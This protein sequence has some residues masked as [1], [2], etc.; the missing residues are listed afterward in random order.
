M[1]PADLRGASF[2]ESP[3][4]DDRTFFALPNV[5]LLSL[6]V[7]SHD[8]PRT[9]LSFRMPTLVESRALAS[10]GLDPTTHRVWSIA[11]EH[12]DLVG[13]TYKEGD[14]VEVF[15]YGGGSSTWNGPATV[16]SVSDD[17]GI[18]VVRSDGRS[19]SGGFSLDFIR[20]LV[21]A[22][23]PDLS[24]K[25]VRMGLSI[26]KAY[27]VGSVWNH[28]S[29][30]TTPV[31]VVGHEGVGMVKVTHPA[32]TTSTGREVAAYA[33]D[34]VR[35]AFD[36]FGTLVS[37]TTEPVKDFEN[38]PDKARETVEERRAGIEVGDT[39]RVT[40][41]WGDFRSEIVG[42][43]GVVNQIDEIDPNLPFRVEFD[44]PHPVI[45]DSYWVHA[46]EKVEEAPFSVGQHVTLKQSVGGI[47][48]PT[49]SVIDRIEDTTV[50]L[51][52]NGTNFEGYRYEGVIQTDFGNVQLVDRPYSDMGYLTTKT[53]DEERPA[54]LGA[55]MAEAGA[56]LS[57]PT[58]VDRLR[59]E[60]ETLK[61]AASDE[62]RRLVAETQEARR[63]HE[64][65]I[66]TIGEALIEEAT[67]RDWCSE[68]DTVVN[69]MNGSLNI[70][71]PL[72][73]TE[74]TV[75]LRVMYDVEITVTR[76]CD[77]SEDDVYEKAEENFHY[78]N[79]SSLDPDIDRIDINED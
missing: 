36:S 29:T 66:R 8:D 40:K 13:S 43:E 62:R 44:P 47:K 45:G 30:G 59:T 23:K 63:K 7:A 31:T 56:V 4:T 9:G 54:S 28:I 48:T 21:E 17:I 32:Y 41:T 55:A 34:W 70:E 27:P 18:I 38:D 12:Y 10:V 14:R 76:Q 60:I 57:E 1:R 35:A 20:P 53:S 71:L 69:D 77:D 5:D 2:W 11:S 58:E 15:G 49:R 37:L 65:D 24:N 26:E 51:K 79:L 74:V 61:Q 52:D 19:G 78:S 64:E 72:R 73:Q 42:S 33:G 16:E 68:Y 25:A 6:L 50:Y 75:S 39:V 22:P 46:V 3:H 67:N